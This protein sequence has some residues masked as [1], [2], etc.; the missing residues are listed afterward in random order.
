MEKYGYKKGDLLITTKSNDSVKKDAYNKL[1]KYV[2][3]KNNDYT[4]K[5]GVREKYK[6]DN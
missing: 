3:D 2:L 4:T 1:R 5:K 6:K